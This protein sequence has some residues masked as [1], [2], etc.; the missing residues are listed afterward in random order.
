VADAEVFKEPTALAEIR[1]RTEE[2]LSKYL[3]LAKKLGVPAQIRYAI[4]TD[5]IDEAEKL[6]LDIVREM[7]QTTFFAG[8]VLFEREHWY[9]R[10][11]HNETAYTIQKRMQWAGKTMV[12]LPARLQ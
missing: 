2:N 4:G 5:L 11:L 7:P 9:H 8:K 6:C 1:S 10:L 12:I 3:E